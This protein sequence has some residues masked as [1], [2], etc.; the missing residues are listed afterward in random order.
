MLDQFNFR[1][2]SDFLVRNL[3]YDTGADFNL[4]DKCYVGLGG[5]RA[6]PTFAGSIGWGAHFYTIH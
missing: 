3:I 5:K 4:L 6:H 2:M 1:A